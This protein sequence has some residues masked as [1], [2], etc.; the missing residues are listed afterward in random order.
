MIRLGIRT[1]FRLQT[2]RLEREGNNGE[3][4]HERGR[5]G[6]RLTEENYRVYISSY[7]ERGRGRERYMKKEN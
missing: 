7:L 3:R 4:T 2:P 5:G 1:G 6:R